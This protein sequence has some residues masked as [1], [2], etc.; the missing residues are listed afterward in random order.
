MEDP[1]ERELLE[2]LRRLPAGR[3]EAL[4]RH[5]RLLATPAPAARPVP[6]GESVVGALRRLCASYPQL[7]RRRLLAAAA[8]LLAAH[9]LHGRPA[10]EVID[11]LEALFHSHSLRR[12]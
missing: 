8:D 12:R 1:I 6:A 3:Q 7:N 4:L 5:A 2:L 11:E 10:A 9:S